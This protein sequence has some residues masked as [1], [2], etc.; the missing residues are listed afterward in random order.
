ESGP[1]KMPL[2]MIDILAA[3]QL[4]E[5]ILEALIEQ[6]LNDKAYH[7][8]V[9]LYDTAVASLANQA[10]N[11]L[12]ADHLPRP[13]GSLHPNIA[14][15]GEIFETLDK[16]LVTLAIGSDGQFEKLFS[17]LGLELKEEF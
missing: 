15:Y 5:G 14:P 13:I 2:A 11:Y 16:K 1:V 6:Q 10:S 9:S 17:L 8:E 12:M 7:I 3:H 4:K